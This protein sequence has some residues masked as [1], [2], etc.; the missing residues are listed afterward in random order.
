MKLSTFFQFARP[1][2]L[3]HNRRGF[4][5]VCGHHSI[6]VLND[7]LAMIRNHAICVRC[8]SVA[9]NR[10]VAKCILEYFKGKGVTRLSDFGKHP[11]IRV[12]NSFAFGSI[13]KMMGKCSNIICSEYFSDV[14]PG[15]Y[16]DDILCEDFENLSFENSIFD[17]VISEDVFEHL[18][19]F[20]KGFKEVYRVLKK[21][22]AHIFCIPYCFGK[23]TKALFEYKE[24]KEVPLAPIEYHGDPVRGQ[25]P[26]YTHFGHDLIDE[27]EEMGYDI[28]LDIAGYEDEIRFGTYNCFSFVTIK[29]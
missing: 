4:C 26:T 25:I 23:K 28:V 20:R 29:R 18:K 24:G 5:T 19:D 11:E 8:G 9:R 17:L 22:G 13:N 7:T 3:F 6:F 21:G 14:K 12:F 27:L 2:Y 15:E 16:R 10:H 1:R